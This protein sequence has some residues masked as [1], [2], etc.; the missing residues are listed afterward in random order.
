[1]KHRLKRLL[2]KSI[3]TGFIAQDYYEAAKNSSDGVFLKKF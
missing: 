2:I 3:S 1:M